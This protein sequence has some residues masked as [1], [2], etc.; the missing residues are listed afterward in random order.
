MSSSNFGYQGGSSAPSLRLQSRQSPASSQSGS[1]NGGSGSLSS[2][3]APPQK[4]REPRRRINSAQFKTPSAAETSELAQIVVANATPPKTQDKLRKRASTLSLTTTTF[5]PPG[6]LNPSIAASTLE[7][8]LG[9]V[10]LDYRQRYEAASREAKQWEKKYSSAQNQLH[11][12]RERW[13]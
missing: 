7:G 5:M 11:Y 6:S 9:N 4:L 2:S 13:E 10:E 12:E 1:R 8:G 3:T